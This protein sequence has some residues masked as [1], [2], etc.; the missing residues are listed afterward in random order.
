MSGIA[1]AAV[2]QRVRNRS[3]PPPL[4]FD[5]AALPDDALLT[6][7]E[8]ADG[9]ALRSRPLKVGD[10]IT[11]NGGRPGC[12]SRTGHATDWATSGDGCSR[13]GRPNLVQLKE[14]QPNPTCSSMKGPVMLA[15][16]TP[17]EPDRAQIEIFVDAIFRHARN[18]VISL[19]A[20]Y[21]SANKPFR[22]TPIPIASGFAFVC[23]A[24]E[25]DARRAS[26]YPKPIVFCPPLAL[27]ADDQRA[28]EQDIV[29]GL[30]L[31]AECDQAPAAARVELERRL[32]PA[33]VVVHSGGRWKN[34][35]SGNDEDKIHLHW[36][37]AKPASGAEQLARL[38]QARGL[39]ARLVGA[40]TS[41]VPICHPIRWPGS[42]HRKAEPRLCEIVEVDPDREID[43][44]A[45]L[46]GL[47]A[48]VEQPI[49]KE[50]AAASS[51]QVDWGKSI[52]QIISG[53]SYHPTLVP[54][55]ASCASHRVPQ[56]AAD[57]LLGA[58]LANSAPSDPER[59]RRRQNELLKLPETVASAY[60]KFGS[61]KQLPPLILG[62]V[63]SCRRSRLIFCRRL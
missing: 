12:S 43:L 62:N 40:D 18:G 41:N 6:S 46:A 47:G 49:V 2:P 20:F 8:L 15:P 31:S 14:L 13:I 52:R 4:D 59:E 55:A 33:T 22:V 21:E 39:V 42:W 48:Q 45:A 28:R 53:S 35:A 16:D 5:P 29:E 30:A 23:D 51:D 34:P 63:T 3:V 11:L 36:R 57:K 58:L 56:Q 60:R 10:C 50:I 44:D 25:D 61:P 54:L 1:N 9:F 26:Q 38:K 37:L 27:F 32:G 24:T 19:R 17:L 7:R